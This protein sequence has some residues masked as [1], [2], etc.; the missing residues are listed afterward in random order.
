MLLAPSNQGREGGRNN[1]FD[2][3]ELLL[4]RQTP[5]SCIE[6]GFGGDTQR[7]YV[8]DN[9]LIFVEFN[10]EDFPFTNADAGMTS[11]MGLVTV[12]TT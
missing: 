3:V 5:V 10:V 9:L 6:E 1:E 2:F 12:L 7:E 8:N 11:L 4:T